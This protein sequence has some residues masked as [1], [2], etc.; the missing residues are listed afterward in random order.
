MTSNLFASGQPI[1]HPSQPLELVTYSKRNNSETNNNTMTNNRRL[2]KHTHQACPRP[3]R[4]PV[5]L[6]AFVRHLCDLRLLAGPELK[7]MQEFD[8]ISKVG[9]W[10]GGGGGGGGEGGSS[11][12]ATIFHF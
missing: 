7:L 5:D 11:M 3:W 6:E 10:E 9:V 8:T 4:I 12:S 1:G 2:H